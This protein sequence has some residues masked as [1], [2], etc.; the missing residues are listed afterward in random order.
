MKKVLNR[1]AEETGPKNAT[2]TK[3]RKVNR[4]RSK[5]TLPSQPTQANVQA[6]QNHRHLTYH[7]D[8]SGRR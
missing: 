1:K 7:E 4:A 3:P 5:K 8:T 2:K 6:L